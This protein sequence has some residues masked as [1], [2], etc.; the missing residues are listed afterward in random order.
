MSY[1]I[2]SIDNEYNPHSTD[3]FRRYIRMVQDG[4]KTSNLIPCVGSYKGKKENAFMWSLQDFN[5]HVRGS[6]FVAQQESILHVASGNKME[7]DLEYLQPDAPLE[8]EFIGCMHHVCKEE[9]LAS[10]AYTYR[11]YL[12]MYWVAKHGNPDGSYRRSKETFQ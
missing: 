11:P 1:V 9:A 6:V 3:I 8:A 7:A 5:E 10:E 12:N 4:A 2:F